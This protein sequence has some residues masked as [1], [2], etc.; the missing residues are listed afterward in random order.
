[1]IG[2][3]NG[4]WLEGYILQSPHT[5]NRNISW[6][7]SVHEYYRDPLHILHNGRYTVL[8]II[9]YFIIDIILMSNIVSIAIT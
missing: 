5:I 2:C 6:W 3:S 4:K 9:V 7:L 8:Q 1:M